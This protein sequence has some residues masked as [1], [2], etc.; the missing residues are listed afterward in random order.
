MNYRSHLLAIVFCWI[1]LSATAQKGES[2]LKVK[3]ALNSRYMSTNNEGDLAD[4]NAMVAFGHLKFD[5]KAKP[6]LSLTVQVN[7][8]AIP[9]TKGIERRDAQTGMGPVYEAALYN[10]RTMDGNSEFALPILNAQIEHDGHFITLGRFLKD[11]Q[12]FRTEQWPFPNALE[13]VWYENYKA[14]KT[15]WQLAYIHRLAPRFSGDFETV[16]QSIGVAPMGLDETG[17]PSQYRGNV[18]SK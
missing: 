5:Y 1:S 3:G 14:E 13:G 18:D 10:L 8:L 9:S 11:S 7:G 12:I 17:N 6:W 15:S 4:F 16:G 2:L